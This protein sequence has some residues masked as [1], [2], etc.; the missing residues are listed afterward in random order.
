MKILYS[1]KFSAS[2]N[3][4]FTKTVYQQDLLEH[5]CYLQ[6]LLEEGK[7]L[8]AGPFTNHA[9]GQVI[10]NVDK[11]EEAL[12]IVKNDPAVINKIFSYEINRW[13]IRFKQ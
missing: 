1:I 12:S 13:H 4:D 10:L 9:G 3:Y 11:E 5:G 8:L 2:E 7:L 6:K